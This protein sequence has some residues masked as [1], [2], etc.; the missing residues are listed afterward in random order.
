MNFG[1][2]SAEVLHVRGDV[3]FRPLEAGIGIN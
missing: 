1:P 2:S 3:R